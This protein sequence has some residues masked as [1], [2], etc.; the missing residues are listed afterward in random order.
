MECRRFTHVLR[1]EAGRD[2]LQEGRGGQAG[3]RA[4][5]SKHTMGLQDGYGSQSL[6]A[7]SSSSSPGGRRRTDGRTEPEG[8]EGGRK[9]GREEERDDQFQLIGNFSPINRTGGGAAVGSKVKS[10]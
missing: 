5:S 8:E 6:L 4:H 10:Q 2:R 7:S 1:R 9:E 3:G